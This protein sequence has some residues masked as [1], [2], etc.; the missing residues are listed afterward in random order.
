MYSSNHA[1]DLATMNTTTVNPCRRAIEGIGHWEFRKIFYSFLECAITTRCCRLSRD[2]VT[3][4][5]DIDWLLLAMRSND[6]ASRFSAVI[7]GISVPACSEELFLQTSVAVSIS[8]CW[9]SWLSASCFW[10]VN[11]VRILVDVVRVKSCVNS[12]LVLRVYQCESRSIN[13]PLFQSSKGY[14]VRSCWRVL[15]RPKSWVAHYL[16]E[17]VTLLVL[18]TP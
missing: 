1:R 2:V 14:S 6:H 17:R 3:R 11:K 16:S 10:N 8:C 15:K 4:D 18:Q 9:V 13:F 7:G 12:F 5:V